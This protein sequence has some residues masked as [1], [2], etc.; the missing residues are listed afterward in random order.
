MSASCKKES[1][2]AAAAFE[3]CERCFQTQS[4]QDAFTTNMHQQKAIHVWNVVNTFQNN[5]GHVWKSRAKMSSAEN[6]RWPSH[7]KP[8]LCIYSLPD[9][10]TILFKLSKEL[11]TRAVLLQW[12][13]K[14]LLTAM[15]PSLS[16]YSAE[17]TLIIYYQIC[18]YTWTLW[19]WRNTLRNSTVVS[20]E[21]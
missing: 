4:D 12:W 20:Q 8:S 21:L 15:G 9:I 18:I 19:G 3:W 5:N 11:T 2:V 7:V 14:C 16:P 13:C 10:G 1:S 17:G 6:S